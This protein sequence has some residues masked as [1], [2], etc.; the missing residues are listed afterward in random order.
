[1]IKQILTT[2]NEILN[3]RCVDTVAPRALRKNLMDTL[4]SLENA[5]G[6]AAPQIGESVRAFALRDEER[7]VTVYI[8]PVITMASVIVETDIEGCLSM[9]MEYYQ[10][11]RSIDIEFTHDKGKT[12]A[13]GYEARCIQHEIN[14]LD[15]ILISDI[16]ERIIPF[17]SKKNT[18]AC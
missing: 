3:T 7:I 12:S 8:N 2:P 10:V 4:G 1:M 6:L 17:E 11:S 15:G 13:S 9:P 18:D 5:I 14:H 16:G